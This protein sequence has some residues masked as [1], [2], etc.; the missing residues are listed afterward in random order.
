MAASQRRTASSSRPRCKVSRDRSS[1]ARSAALAGH[2]RSVAQHPRPERWKSGADIAERLALDAPQSPLAACR[3]DRTALMAR[4]DT[5]VAAVSIR[6][7]RSAE[8]PFHQN[9][10]A[11]PRVGRR[12]TGDLRSGARGAGRAFVHAAIDDA[13]R[14]AVAKP[15]PEEKRGSAKRCAVHIFRW[16]Q[17]RGV[18]AERAR[19]LQDR[20]A[21]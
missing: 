5:A 2:W 16:F 13:G 3:R 18:Q 1:A 15:P 10:W 4:A 7:A 9:V 11:S 14:L 8:P 12:I 17:N 19:T 21:V 20:D 6:T